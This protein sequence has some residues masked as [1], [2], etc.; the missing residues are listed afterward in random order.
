MGMLFMLM[1]LP[2]DSDGARNLAAGLTSLM[3][4][5]SY[6]TSSLMAEKVG[7]FEA[8]ET[9]KDYMM[10]VIRNHARAASYDKGD[11]MFENLS[12]KPLTINHTVLKQ[13]GMN[14]IGQALRSVWKNTIISGYA[15]GFRNAQV[16]VLAPTGTIAFAMDCATTSSEPFFSHVTFKKLVGGSYME[17]VNPAIPSALKK[18]GYP[19]NEI[20]EIVKYVMRKTEQGYIA[21]GKIEGA[22]YLKAE[23]FGV[24]DTANKCGSGIRYIPP[25]GHVRMM[26]ALTPHVTG[27]ISKTVNLPR[28]ATPEEIKDIYMLSGKLGVKAIAQYRDGCKACQPLRTGG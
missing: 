5:Y 19:E 14:N 17:I 6:Y 2:Y 11:A 21:D 10:T 15:N 3:T 16:S 7:A 20:D 26:G 8:Y 13:I 28:E 23:H 1:G 9:N 22:P 12:Y 27:A 25:E 4:G 24:F 18:L